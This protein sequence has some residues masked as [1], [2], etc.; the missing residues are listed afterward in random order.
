[1]YMAG[2]P[3]IFNDLRAKPTQIAVG[4][5]SGTSYDGIDAALVEI[6][7]AGAQTRLKLLAFEN[8]RFKPV[9]RQKIKELFN[10]ETATVERICVMNYYLGELF[11][12]AALKLIEQAGLRPAEIDFIGS[13]GQTI[14]HIPEPVM[15]GGRS[16]RATLQIGEP[17]VIAERTGILTVADFRVRDVAAGGQGAPLTAYADYLLF[18]Q[19]RQI[20]LI[21]NIGGIGNVTLVGGSVPFEGVVAFDTGPGNMIIDEIANLVTNGQL[22]YDQDGLMAARGKVCADLLAELLTH[23][24][25][26]KQPPKTTGREK[27]GIAFAKAVWEAGKNRGLSQEDLLATVTAF[28]VEAIAGSYERFI[29]PRYRPDEVIIGGGGAYNPTLFQWLQQ[30]LAPIPVLRHEAFGISSDAKEALLF[31]ILANE[32]LHGIP[33]NVPSATGARHPVVLGKVVLP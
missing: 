8:F 18:G 10:L 22:A 11:A 30:R 25:L 24:Y 33:A 4:L 19:E 21:Q 32:T 3:G 2:L 29:Y 9:D 23:P 5:N 16:I 6:T 12:A 27:F 13:H 1:M 15:E 14:Y 31:A 28:T 7:G 26:A 20:R 17:A